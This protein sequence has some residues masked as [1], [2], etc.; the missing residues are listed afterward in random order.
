M[1]LLYLGNSFGCERDNICAVG[2]GK[3]ET[4]INCADIRIV[5]STNDNPTVGQDQPIVS[6]TT[7]MMM[8]ATVEQPAETT[9]P[10]AADSN[11]VNDDAGTDAAGT[12]L[13]CVG[14]PPY[15]EIPGLDVWCNN[16][17]NVGN[18]P[19]TICLCT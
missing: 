1:Y 2:L 3:Q 5:S 9:T 19:A 12:T 16:N 10:G 17:C 15:S 13:T 8:T 4:F 18:C 14:V 7:H 11:V 6:P